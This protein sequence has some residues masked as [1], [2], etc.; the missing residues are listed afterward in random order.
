MIVE[1]KLHSYYLSEDLNKP[2]PINNHHFS[3]DD[4]AKNFIKKYYDD[5]HNIIVTDIKKEKAYFDITG[6]YK[7]DRMMKL[8]SFRLYVVYITAYTQNSKF[9]C[10][11][12]HVR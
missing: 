5:Q 4:A 6:Y 12:G 1:E 9:N 10:T 7:G 2:S 11:Y 3:D 8:K